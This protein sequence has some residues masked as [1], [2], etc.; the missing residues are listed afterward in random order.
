MAGEQNKPPQVGPGGEGTNKRP[1][2]S[3]NG[4]NALLKTWNHHVPRELHNAAKAR[5]GLRQLARRGH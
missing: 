5:Y 1:V 2:G 4:W 3:H